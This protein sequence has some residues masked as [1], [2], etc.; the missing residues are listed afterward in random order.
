[1]G[2]LFDSSAATTGAPDISVR[3][4]PTTAIRGSCG[5]TS[6][7]GRVPRKVRGCAAPHRSRASRLLLG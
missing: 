6:R 1:M 4:A 3:A 7:L 2:G 5:T